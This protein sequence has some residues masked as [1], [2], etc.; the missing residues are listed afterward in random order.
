MDVSGCR[1]VFGFGTSSKIGHPA[2]F[3]AGM[4]AGGRFSATAGAGGALDAL[5]NA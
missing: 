3:W 1:G 4:A 2:P 5:E